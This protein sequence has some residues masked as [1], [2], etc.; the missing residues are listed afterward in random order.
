MTE[1]VVNLGFHLYLIISCL[2]APLDS[3]Q[4]ILEIYEDSRHVVNFPAHRTKDGFTIYRDKE[5]KTVLAVISEKDGVYSITA[6]GKTHSIDNTKL[7][8]K[9]LKTES[10]YSRKVQS[11]EITFE[12][13]KGVRKVYQDINNKCFIIKQQPQPADDA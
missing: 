2:F 10:N 12:F 11:S 13:T 8:I 5:E 1:S 9:P 7:K 3:D 4:F 6:H